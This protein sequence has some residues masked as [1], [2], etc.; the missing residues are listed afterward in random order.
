MQYTRNM[1][2][3]GVHGGPRHRPRRRAQGVLEQSTATL[4]SRRCSASRTCSSRSTRWT[5]SA[6][7]Q[8]RLDRSCRVRTTGRRSWT[9]TTSVHPVQRAPRRQRRAALDAM[10]WYKGPRCSTTSKHVYTGSDVNLID[11]RFPVQWVIRP[12]SDEH[13]DYRGYAGQVAAGVFRVGDDVVV[14][15]SGSPL[16]RRGDRG[17]PAGRSNEASRPRRSSSAW[18]TTSTSRAATSSPAPQP[19]QGH[20]DFEARSLDGRRRRRSSRAATT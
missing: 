12:Q 20:E 5:S 1:V 3:G 15:P 11:V 13:H 16:A 14:L 8:G 2:T 4:P 7:R 9:S 18:P 17:R 6:G 19:A 10:A